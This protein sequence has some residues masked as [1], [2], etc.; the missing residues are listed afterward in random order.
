MSQEPILRALVETRLAWGLSSKEVASRIGC[1]PDTF[2]H[3]ERGDK[4]PNFK[5]LMRWAKVLGYDIGLR[6]RGVTQ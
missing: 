4:L 3:I 2:S 1:R 6:S 5:V